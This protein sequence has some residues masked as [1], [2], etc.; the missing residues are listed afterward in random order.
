MK[1]SCFPGLHNNSNLPSQCKDSGILLLACKLYR[2]LSQVSCKRCGITLLG[3]QQDPTQGPTTLLK[4]RRIA[5]LICLHP[6]PSTRK[7]H[8]CCDAKNVPDVPN[9]DGGG[10]KVHK[11]WL[12]V[13]VALH[14][15]AVARS[16]WVRWH[17]EAW[18]ADRVVVDGVEVVWRV[19][20]QAWNCFIIR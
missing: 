19:W 5:L 10:L 16:I 8:R 14:P 6:T 18:W 20:L 12:V 2:P 13:G 11:A 3:S 7:V 17:W 1:H 4:K 15:S 9:V